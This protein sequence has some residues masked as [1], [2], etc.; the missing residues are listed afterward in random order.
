MCAYAQ[1]W[2]DRLARE[3][4]FDHRADCPHGENLFCMWSSN[5]NVKVPGN[6]PVDSWYSEEA[7]YAYGGSQGCMSCGHFTQVVW[8][9]SKQLGIAKARSPRT[10]KVSFE[11]IL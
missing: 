6:A 4:R 3:D 8:R 1:S 11:T 7:K 10:G 5:K 9:D 2:A